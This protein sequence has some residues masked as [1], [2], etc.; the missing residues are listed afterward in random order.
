MCKGHPPLNLTVNGICKC[1]DLY[2]LPIVTLSCITCLSLTLTHAHTLTMHTYSVHDRK[3]S[4]LGFCSLIQAAVKP[5]AFVGAAPKIIPA[6]IK[7]ME[8]LVEAYKRESIS[9][10]SV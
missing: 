4:V 9:L 3:V 6:M 1:G 7:Q 8:G 5:S 10:V 2:Q